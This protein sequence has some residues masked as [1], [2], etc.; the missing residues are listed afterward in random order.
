MYLKMYTS[1]GQ[2]YIIHNTCRYVLSNVLS[3]VLSDVLSDVPNT[4]YSTPTLAYLVRQHMSDLLRLLSI[5][6]I[7]PRCRIQRI[8]SLRFCV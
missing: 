4:R 2:E 5:V 6:H 3:N 1:L 7:L 8:V